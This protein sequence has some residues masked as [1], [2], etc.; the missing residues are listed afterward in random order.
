MTAGFLIQFQLEFLEIRGLS[1]C[2]TVKNRITLLIFLNKDTHIRKT[3]FAPDLQL[4]AR[5][6]VL[7]VYVDTSNLSSDTPL[8]VRV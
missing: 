4:F 2:Q 3:L 8:L 5:W 6:L 1:G 7:N